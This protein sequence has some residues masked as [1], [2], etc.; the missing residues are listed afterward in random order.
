MHRII[1]ENG[2]LYY[3]NRTIREPEFE[4][5]IVENAASIF[6]QTGIYFDKKWLIGRRRRGAGVPDG[7]YLDLLFPSAPRLYLVEIELCIHDLYTHIVRQ[8]VNFAVAFETDR[9]KIKDN[10]LAD[11]E[12]DEEKRRKVAA[13]LVQSPYRNIHELVDRAVFDAPPAV[14][15]VID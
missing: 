12:R 11:I 7:Y 9:Q 5:A 4:R 14:I 2:E 1:S 3:R 13:Y 6:G 8:I 10:L 15:I